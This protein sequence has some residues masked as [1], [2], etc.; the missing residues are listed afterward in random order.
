MDARDG[1]C[2]SQTLPRRVCVCVFVCMHT[3]HCF[4]VTNE[5]QLNWPAW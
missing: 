1:T 4:V 2:V 5:E 3:C